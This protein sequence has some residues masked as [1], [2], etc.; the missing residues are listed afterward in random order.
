M[1]KLSIIVVGRDD[2]YGDDTLSPYNASTPDTFCFRMK[3]TI[4]NNLKL[5]KEKKQ[6]VEYVVVDWSPIEGKTLDKNEYTSCAFENEEVKHVIVPPKSVAERGWN[7]KNFYEYYAKNVGA[8]NSSGDYVLITNP[9]IMF[10]EEIVESVCK[11]L[12]VDTDENYY[13]PYSRIDV[14]NSLETLAEGITFVPADG[15]I[16]T[17]AAGDFLLTKKENFVGYD[18]THDTNPN[19]QQTNMDSNIL[20]TMVNLGIRPKPLEGSILHLDHGKPHEKEG[21]INPSPYKNRDD[22]GMR[23]VEIKTFENI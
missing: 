1:K 2:G 5:F 4:E 7:P 3:R 22:W 17:P 16:G 19:K 11:C 8:R 21:F 18:E 10:T 14:S 12:S 15:F 9:D 6:D 13:R 23:K 20:Y